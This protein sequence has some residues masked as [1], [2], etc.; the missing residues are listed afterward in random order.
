MFLWSAF[1]PGYRRY[2]QLALL[3]KREPLCAECGY[4]ITGLVSPRCPECG[5]PTPIAPPNAGKSQ[6]EHG[7]KR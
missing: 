2:R 3:A 6:P 1:S 5:T 7:A 4:R